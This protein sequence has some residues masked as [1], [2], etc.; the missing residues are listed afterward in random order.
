MYYE[1]LLMRDLGELYNLKVC[2]SKEINDL[3]SEAINRFGLS[4][5]ILMENAGNAVF[6]TISRHMEVSKRKFVAFCGDGRNGGDGFVV[7]RKIHS[8][9]GE[10]SV[11][12]LGRKENMAKSTSSNFEILSKFPIKIYE[13][14][15][16]EE[17]S[18]AI[19][20]SDAI[21][22]ALFGTGLSREISG[23]YKTIIQMINDSGKKVF[24][25][26]IPSGVNANS[27]EVMGISVKAD[28]TITFG[29]PKIGNVLY[30]G[31]DF[32]GRLFVSHISFPKSLYASESIKVET[33]TPREI[34]K[35]ER[36]SQK[37]DYGKSLFIAGSQNY[38]GAPYFSALSFLKAGGGLS[39]LATPKSISSLIGA[40]GSE[41][42]L[43]PQPETDFLSLSRESVDNI[44]DFSKKID[45]VVLGP[46]LSLN[47]ETQEATRQIALEID[48][49]LLIDADG[50]T[51]ISY[52]L[53]IL[54]KR[55]KSTILTP[56]LGEM[57][58]IT[59][60]KLKE[61]DKRKIEVLQET[62]K[63]LNSI[64]VLKGPHS[65]IGYPEENVLINLS[66]NPGMA[67]AGSGD[68][69]PGT[70]AAMNGQGIPIEKAVPMGV[71]IH[72]LA[73]DLAAEEMGEHGMT[74]QDILNYLPRAIKY[75]TENF[76]DII[77]KYTLCKI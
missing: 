33:F 10:I 58:R 4:E 38:L 8:S 52:D 60:R 25:V 29:L 55:K 32:S 59:G 49:P 62:T 35:R 42:V 61:I 18:D 5:E 23:T 41:I 6:S 3:D 68:L 51:A 20:K 19:D 70:I 65:L 16:L 28:Y 26:D 39:Y 44:L 77:R 56:H 24:S 69:L 31:Y 66:G 54:R 37:G 76:D 36:V 48:K 7:A 73:G 34:P 12:L 43:L 45:F 11:F 64:I 21:I 40:K 74:A 46:G 47:D 15:I 53:E 63:R 71:F 67:T 17:V 2:R 75:H 1:I 57:A 9:R 72:G 22:D 14:L 13:K 30:P 27:A 50:I